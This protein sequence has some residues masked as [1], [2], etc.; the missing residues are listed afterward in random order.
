MPKFIVKSGPHAGLEIP[1][2]GKRL[3]FGRSDECDVVLTDG[4]VS[5]VHAHAI[6]LDGLVALVDLNSSNGTFV[7]E[8]PISRILLMDGD[9]IRLGETVLVF[10]DAETGGREFAGA[11]LA[12]MPR[13]QSAPASP[14]TPLEGTE[15]LGR[16]QLFAPIPDDMHVEALKEIYLKL[17]ALYRVFQE[18]SQSD[19]LS[20]MF[21]AVGRALTISTGAE[22]VVFFLNAEKTGE[23]WHKFLTH[24]ASKVDER[25][26]ASPVSE[27]LLARAR[28][29]LRMVPAHVEPDGETD[30]AQ[31]QANAIAA[32]VVRGGRLLAVLYV[33]NPATGEPFTKDD[34]DFVYTL[35]LQLAVRLNQVE[36]V[37]QLRQENVELR[38]RVD[39]DF[40]IIVR[41]EKMKAVMALTQRVAGSD[42]TVLV[43]G[44]SGTGKE[45]I[46]RAIHH[47]SPRASKPLVAVNCAALPETLLESELFGHEKGAFTGAHERRIGKFELAD[48]GT[49]FLDEIGD[50]S[51]A[52]QAKLLRA[53]QEGEITRVGGTKT[54]K[55]NVRVITATNK[56][57]AEEVRQGRFRQDL[58][59]RL[60][61]I[62]IA[63]P[64]LRDRPDDIPVL[65]EHFL[66]QLRQKVPTRVKAFSPEALEVLKRYSFP[67]NVR[68]LRNLV[69]RAL[70][71]A[72]GET[73]LPEHF[74]VELLEAAGG[75]LMIPAADNEAPQGERAVR[76]DGTPLPLS[77]VE[78]NHILLVLRHVRGNKLRAAAILGISRTT[79][80]EKLKLYGLT[81]D[82]TALT[83]GDTD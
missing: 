5:R 60:K 57:L 73:I 19:T 35:S 26:A 23:T 31:G 30:F 37:Q 1:L 48:G 24:T 75:G 3:V 17:K 83:D 78:R 46:A 4:N 38:R 58:Y 7:N 51:A 13:F 64:A 72:T 14:P 28:A 53:L 18:V 25:Q 62:D 21:E 22:R 55:V 66:K 71:F 49:L 69:E 59:F 39:A 70:V 52:A 6:V 15:E 44:E 56:N 8:L 74:P 79:L 16:T 67:G 50:I 77:E 12:S 41:D 32:P 34:A 61:V 82:G 10:C 63:L 42:S 2:V 29:D 27:A 80:Y 40:A 36:Q 76:P 81:G 9:E 65:A 20:D 54:I 47:F 68:E 45:L 43:T 11:P 33:D